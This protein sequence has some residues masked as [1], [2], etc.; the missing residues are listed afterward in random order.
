M[1]PVVLQDCSS[2]N[3]DIVVIVPTLKLTIK[4]THIF[5]LPCE[6]YR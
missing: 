3:P 5:P 6:A 2:V 1:S 4:R